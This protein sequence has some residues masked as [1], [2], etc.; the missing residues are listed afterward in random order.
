MIKKIGQIVQSFQHAQP[1][2][3]KSL[4][5]FLSEKN[6]NCHQENRNFQNVQQLKNTFNIPQQRGEKNVKCVCNYIRVS[7]LQDFHFWVNCPFKIWYANCSNPTVTDF[8]HTEVD[9]IPTN[10]HTIVIPSVSASFPLNIRTAVST[11]FHISPHVPL[12]AY[13]WVHLSCW[14]H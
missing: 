8:R 12:A 4:M 14:R 10:P 6:L 2:G 7:K 13:L 11:S 9:L 5:Q 3:F 1:W